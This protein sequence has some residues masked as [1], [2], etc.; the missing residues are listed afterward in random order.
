M[1]RR[2]AAYLIGETAGEL[3][4]ALDAASVPYRTAA[5]SRRPSR[6][7]G[8]RG[9]A[10]SSCSPACASYDQ[11]TN[12]EE[13]GD[14]FRRL[15][16]E[17]RLW[18]DRTHSA[19]FRACSLDTLEAR[20]G[21]RRPKAP[22]RA[23]ST[24]PALLR[25]PRGQDSAPAP[26]QPDEPR[27][28]RAAPARPRDARTRRVRAR[29]GLQRHLRRG[30]RRRRRPERLPQAPGRL[31]ARRHRADDRAARFDYHGLRLLAP[32]LVVAA[33]ALCL[34]VLVVAPEINGARRWLQFGPATF[35]PS[36]LAKVALCVWV[37]AHLARRPAPRSLG[38]LAKPV[39]LLTGRLLR[40]A[41][42]PARPRHDDHA[43]PDAARR[44]RSSPGRRRGA[45]RRRSARAVLGVAAIWL[46]PYR[47]ARLLSFLDPWQD[48]EGAGLPVGAGDHRLRLGRPH[49]RGPRPGRPEDL[50]PPRGA[51][52]HDLRD[53]RRGA[54]AARL[55]ARDL[56]RSPSS[57]TRASASRCAAATRSGSG[58][59][60]ASRR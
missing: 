17:L 30:G 38:E 16:G 28:A 31:R 53:R 2:R 25:A 18:T 37:A 5:R 10:R 14:E 49:R 39:G 23:M 13:R 12:F 55:G 50:L 19:H 52:G 46:E 47:R 40:P 41:H 44:T 57:R 59:P 51:H 3:E 26:K 22:E 60:P 35:Q 54:R 45:R 8:A 56:P 11:F 43:L 29:H 15:V 33:F 20:G 58:S 4:R 7:R 6:G 9:R 34:A 42:A 27:S 32:A 48:P 21:G 24:W 36:E 1:G